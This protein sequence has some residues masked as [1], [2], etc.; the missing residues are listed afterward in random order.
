MAQRH[1]SHASQPTKIIEQHFR[2]PSNKKRTTVS[3]RAYKHTS[4]HTCWTFTA[5][6]RVQKPDPWGKGSCTSDNS[7]ATDSAGAEAA[8]MSAGTRA[9]SAPIMNDVCLHLKFSAD[10][11]QG[12]EGVPPSSD[13]SNNKENE[14]A[15]YKLKCKKAPT[16]WQAIHLGVLLTRLGRGFVSWKR[17]FPRLEAS[18]HQC[19][20]A[21]I[22][23]G[24]NTDPRCQS[25][26][27]KQLQHPQ[28]SPRG[29]RAHRGNCKSST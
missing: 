29:W 17:I 9:A 16:A 13:N 10:T 25:P 24:G 6:C 1:S 28:S 2:K 23:R 3:W 5:Y 21:G 4:L 18:G 8:P 20:M 7:P 14:K 27:A 26:Q 11:P 19:Q 22:Q 12:Q 15:E